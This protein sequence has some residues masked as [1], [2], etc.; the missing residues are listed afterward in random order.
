VQVLFWRKGV[1]AE[2]KG[3]VVYDTSHGNT[4]QIAE[5]IAG[6]LKSSGFE[7]VLFYV[8]DVKKFAC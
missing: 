1:E 3:V 5:T 4:K 8:K 2:M 7:T 6:T